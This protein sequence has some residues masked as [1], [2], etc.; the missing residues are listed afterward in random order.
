MERLAKILTLDLLPRLGVYR[1]SKKLR[2][3]DPFSLFDLT[4]S[5]LRDCGFNHEQSALL[6]RPPQQ[7][8]DSI[9]AWL[10]GHPQ[11]SIITYYDESYP[12]ILKE[13]S[14]PPMLLFCHGNISLLAQP[15]IAIVGSRAASFSGKETAKRLA[16]E[17]AVCGYTITSGLATGIDSCA[18]QG[19]LNANGHTIAVLGSGLDNLYPRSNIT[20][21][22]A[23]VERDGL[24]ISEFW[25][26]VTPYANNFPR[27]NR[28]V[29]GLSLGVVVV[30]AEACS[31]SLI[32]ARLAA[33]QNRE[34][35]AVPG[36]INNPKATGCHKLIHQGAKLIT[37][38]AD[39][40]DELPCL[41]SP[42]EDCEHKISYE[43]VKSN[44]LHDTILDCIDFEVTSIDQ[45]VIR[46]K[47]AVDAV[48]ECIVLLELAGLIASVAGGYIRIKGDT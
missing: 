36:A 27:R 25:P 15:Q 31:G 2:L 4:A 28:V 18:H 30:E 1:L 43:P 13:I 5:E 38:I 34:V 24:I 46:S 29:S 45:M 42:K 11:R 3:R 26:H 12:S 7:K 19:A 14:A 10:S 35:F 40:L 32:T 17:L 6:L 41:L 33:E 37:G 21:A 48:Q 22:S 23:I 8:I 47:C 20:L 16:L 44:E 39:I 9:M